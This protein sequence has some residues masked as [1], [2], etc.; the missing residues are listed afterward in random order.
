MV[1]PIMPALQNLSHVHN[2]I[3]S[4][5]DER[6]PQRQTGHS[7]GTSAGAGQVAV[8]SVAGA[9]TANESVSTSHAPDDSHET[10]AGQ[11]KSSMTWVNYQHGVNLAEAIEPGLSKRMTRD[12]LIAYPGKMSAISVTPEQDLVI[13]GARV[14]PALEWAVANGVLSQQTTYTQ[15]EVHTALSTLDQHLAEMEKAVKSLVTPSPM[16]KNYYTHSTTYTAH[17]IENKSEQYKKYPVA[18][19]D[20]K[21]FSDDFKSDL[22]SKKAS[23]GTLIKH[24]I[25]T[26]PEKDRNVIERGQ[27]ELYALAPAGPQTEPARD[28]F[29]MKVVHDGITRVYTVNPQ[30]GQ[31]SQRDDYK[32]LFTDAGVIGRKRLADGTE[33]NEFTLWKKR[34]NIQE[35]KYRPK[36]DRQGN[37]SINNEPFNSAIYMLSSLGKLPA[38]TQNEN[39]Q[40]APKT[41]FSQR[42]NEIA[43]VISNKLFYVNEDD[44]LSMAKDD[45][46]RVTDQETKD[47]AYIKSRKGFVG[48]LKGFVPFWRGIELLVAG[49]TIEGVS[50]IWIDILSAMLPVERALGGLL[51][52]GAQLVKSTLPAFSKLTNSFKNFSLKPGAAGIN[53]EG[54]V[55]G[56][57]WTQNAS[58]QAAKGIEQF[59]IN[60]AP[61]HSAGPGIREIE[62]NGA[63]YFVADKPDAG[64]GVHY[65][66]RVNDPKDPSKLVSSGIIAQ[67]DKTG[68]WRRAGE[69][70][71]G[72][73]GSKISTLEAPSSMSSAEKFIDNLLR[74]R[75]AT[76]GANPRVKSLADIKSSN[77][78]VP[79]QIY[80]AHTAVGDDASTGLRRAAGTT[81][82][83]DDYLA[84]IVKHTARQGGSGGEVMSFSAVKAKANSFA[85]QYSTKENAVPVFTVDTTKDA[86]SFRTVADIILND[87]ERLVTQ[88]KITRATLLQ[89]TDQLK[90]YE[91][92]VFYIKG[93]VPAGYLVT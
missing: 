84:A 31:I 2:P 67:R 77:F 64:D 62:Y 87:G 90:N 37:E 48:V 53:W 44:L 65:L 16:R 23:Y 21:K 9:A 80:R 29:V 92:E 74:Q 24:L 28:V 39:E 3:T 10:P 69:Q 76:P 89:A 20:E 78:D 19:Y 15:D 35:S 50:Q 93:D 27:V 72:K 60:A 6:A 22:E 14:G 52:G 17:D 70:L 18:V 34:P 59:R 71:M 13:A 63:K 43:N 82:S 75:N 86:G 68:A 40:S 58:A 66:L 1:S 51:K 88:G 11:P 54:G 26:L 47:R 12:E 49:R 61:L 38:P 46:D 79:P 30:L 41:L 73:G 83:G 25:S 55:R 7:S 85:K 91:L 81:T 57:K 36:V 8:G 32:S 5:Q 42:S 56:L 4:S 33:A 45:P